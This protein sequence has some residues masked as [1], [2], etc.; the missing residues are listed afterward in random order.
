MESDIS[1]S[2]YSISSAL[3]LAS[4]LWMNDP[5]AAFGLSAELDAAAEAAAGFFD[6]GA[7]PPPPPPPLCVVPGRKGVCSSRVR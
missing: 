1:K 5:P 3:V 4:N 7:A 2:L 6:F